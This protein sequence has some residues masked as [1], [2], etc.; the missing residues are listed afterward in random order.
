[1]PGPVVLKTGHRLGDLSGLPEDPWLEM[2][3][4][5]GA[6]MARTAWIFR[7]ARL[8]PLG[9]S[10]DEGWLATDLEADSGGDHRTYALDPRGG[11][12]VLLFPDLDGLLRW[13][14]K[15]NDVKP[16]KP[17][18]WSKEPAS[19]ERCLE[20]LWR[21][22]PS[23]LFEAFRDNAWP[24]GDVEEPTV[25]PGTAGWRRLALIWTLAHFHGSR[26][27]AAPLDLE[28]A[29]LT[30][31]HQ[32]LLERLKDLALAIRAN[33]VPAFVTDLSLEGDEEIARAAS[34]WVLLFEGARAEP[35]HEAT[36]LVEKTQGLLTLLQKAVEEL[37]RRELI[38]VQPQ[39]QPR[40]VEDMLEVTLKAPRPEV[41]I[42]RLIE[43]LMES[44]NVEEVFADDLELRR[45]LTAALGVATR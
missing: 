41:V 17:D 28:P 19:V 9:R 36:E 30:P 31:T 10:P 43:E 22:H 8:L 34:E 7:A 23:V 33:T 13:L 5:P 26:E 42:P 21:L 25:E 39:R 16:A 18:E 15:Q 11:N 29:A 27:A 45:I 24:E 14:S 40:L 35:E 4:R 38:E 20:L 2:L 1:M 44:R 12:P 6:D 3:V 32:L 37:I